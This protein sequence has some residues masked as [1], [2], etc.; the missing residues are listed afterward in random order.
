MPGFRML[1][2]VGFWDRKKGQQV[3]E[4]NQIWL[5]SWVCKTSA[6]DGDRKTRNYPRR[7]FSS[8]YIWDFCTEAKIL[9]IQKI[10]S[11]ENWR[12]NTQK[13][14]QNH[15][16]LPFRYLRNFKEE[17]M[18]YQQSYAC[19]PNQKLWLWKYNLS[20]YHFCYI[21][22]CFTKVQQSVLQFPIFIYKG[23]SCEPIKTTW[24][25]FKL[26]SFP[27]LLVAHKCSSFTEQRNCS[28][29]VFD[30]NI[31]CMH[32]CVIALCNAVI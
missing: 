28:S 9:P 26:D 29:S 21:Y 3:R 30:H 5:S 20:R 1:K 31:K 25:F 17:Q 16:H 10:H 32:V 24:L 7:G 4:R 27:R 12:T 6:M 15:F 8:H 14:N 19:C 22:Y 2:E 23:Y 13:W 18:N 11:W